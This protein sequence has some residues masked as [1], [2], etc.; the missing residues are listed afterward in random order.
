MIAAAAATLLLTVNLST[1][2]AVALPWLASHG[3]ELGQAFNV[4]NTT[5]ASPISSK[6][7]SHL[8]PGVVRAGGISADWLAYVVDDGVRGGAS[9][10]GGVASGDGVA[11]WP[12]APT[13]ISLAKVRELIAWH[14]AAG[15]SLLFDLSELFGRN[16]NTTK[17]GCPSCSGWCG[18]PPEYPAWD[19]SNV[20][21][22]LQALHDGGDV[23]GNSSL[24]AFELGNELA[25]HLNPAENVADVKLLAGIIAE[26]WAGE[27]A[28][29]FWA[30]STDHCYGDDYAQTWQILVNIS[31]SV[32]GFTYVRRAPLSGTACLWSAA[33]SSRVLGAG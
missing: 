30:P 32:A 31:G 24:F 25:G 27:T 4:I 1:P 21:A 33:A 18:S 5:L 17:P 28:P 11:Y 14:D 10:A 8:A 12:N 16:C 23:L 19:T 20:R 7:A 29:S 22:L 9:G 2:I 3:W 15:L 6:I 13:N 26:I